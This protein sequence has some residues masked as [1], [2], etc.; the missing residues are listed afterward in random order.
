[1]VKEKVILQRAEFV[2]TSGK[3]VH[4]NQKRYIAKTIWLKH[5]LTKTQWR[6]VI[7]RYPNLKFVFSEKP[8]KQIYINDAGRKN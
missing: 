7:K 1:M 2:T 3:I 4:K 6:Q 5:V 8:K